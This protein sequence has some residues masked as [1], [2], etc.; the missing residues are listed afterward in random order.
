MTKST[1][2][3]SLIKYMGWLIVSFFVFFQ[4]LIQTSTSLMQNDWV[5]QFHLTH[6]T[7]SYLSAA[8]FYTY[9]FFQIPAGLIFDRYSARN[10]LGL[11]SLVLGIGCLLFADS[12]NYGF[13]IFS[14]MLM[15]GGAA[16]AFIGMLK[17]T[18]TLFPGRQ[19]SIMMG[20]SESLAALATMGGIVVVAWFLQHASWQQVM[21][22]CA[23][24]VFAVTA[25]VLVFI[26]T[27]SP[28]EVPTLKLKSLFENIRKACTSRI[29]LITGIYGFFMA[30]I[31]NSFTSLWGIE[32]LTSAY[33]V[34]E[35]Q[36]AKSMSTIFFG[37]AA[38]CPINGYLSNKYA[39]E[40]DAMKICS[41][42]CALLISAVISQYIPTSLLSLTFF[43]IGLLCAVYVQ[44]F[45]IVGQSVNSE[46]EATSMSVTN[47][48]IMSGAPLLQILIG[49]ILNHHSFGFAHSSIRNYQ[50]ALGILPLGMVIAFGLCWFISIGSTSDSQ[51]ELPQAAQ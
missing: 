44:C 16:F 15:G 41:V 50:I 18:S 32:F 2:R 25:M 23:Y 45:A 10:V 38:G 49:T 51:G 7:V 48:L 37:L 28:S 6:L 5:Q 21:K 40:I 30:S 14:R 8:F 1:D 33:H 19:F 31:V 35:L 12:P 27:P 11:S 17:V 36:A 9:L 39:R 34:T 43:F 4:F 13:A 3:K 20:I 24:I 47:M 46:I 22:D 42:V 26:R 29:V